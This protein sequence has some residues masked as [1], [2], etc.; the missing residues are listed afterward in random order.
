MKLSEEVARTHRACAQL[1]GELRRMVDRGG[2]S[3][4]CGLVTGPKE[5]KRSKSGADIYRDSGSYDSAVVHG[6]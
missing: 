2:Q 4:R 1:L 3:I 6:A 5:N